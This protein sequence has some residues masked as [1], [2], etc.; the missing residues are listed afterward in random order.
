MRK[1]L[2]WRFGII[3]TVLLL[4]FWY[5]YPTFKWSSLDK[6]EQ[7]ALMD[8]YRLYDAEHPDP[9]LGER[10]ETYFTRWY[11]GDKT[12]A[13]NLG[14]DLQGGMHLVLQVDSDAAITNE[15]VRQKDNLRKYFIDEGIVTGSMS[16]EN[17]RIVIPLA[18]SSRSEVENAVAKFSQNTFIAT[19][20]GNNLL[21]SLSPD[22]IKNIKSMSVKQAL[23]TIRNRIDEF[24]VAEP[25]IQRQGENRILVQLPGV[26]D[27]DRVKDL[28]GKTA[29]LSFHIVLDGPAPKAQLLAQ[30]NQNIPSNAYLAPSRNERDRG[31]G[32]YYLLQK[33]ALV[34]G[35]DLVDARIGQDELN[36]PAVNFQLSRSG[37]V[38]F[39]KLTEANIGKQLAIVLDDAV[40]SA[41]TIRSRITSHGQITGRFTFQEVE[42]LA[43][44]LRSG[45]LP[46][47]VDIIE[48]RTVGPT[49]G[50]ES[51][52]DGLK[53]GILS[54]VIVA[55]FMIV[56]YRTAGAIADFALFL[57]IFMLLAFLSYFRATLTLPG[58]G[59]I[60]LTIGMAVDANVLVFERIREEIKKGKTLR[61]A[62]DTGYSK[63]FL[64]ILDANVTTLITAIVLFQFGTGPVK[65]FAVTLSAGI[66]ISMFTALF[67][68][69]A[70]FELL[71][72]RQWLK[73]INMGQF[74]GETH[75]PFLSRRHI[76]AVMSVIVIIVGMGT[77]LARGSKNFG[78]DFT[79]GTIL[80]VRFDQP[81]TTEEVRKALSKGGLD[82]VV[83]QRFGEQNGDARDILIRTTLKSADD[84]QTEKKG[85]AALVGEKIE[86]ALKDNLHKSFEV[87][88]TEEVGAAMSKDLTNKALLSIL[89]STIGI[90]IYISLR[91]EFRFG[92]GAVVAVFHDVLITMGA[93][94]LT[95][96]EIQLP[97]VAALLTIFGY[98]INDTI[99]VFDRIRENMRMRRGQD[100]RK[101]M[102]SSINETLSRTIITALT[103]LFAVLV[104]YFVGNEVTRDFAFALF[105]GIIVGTYSSV[106]IATP[107]VYVWQQIFGRG[108]LRAPQ[109]KSQ[110]K[111]KALRV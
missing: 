74:F 79:Q 26:E 64:T 89:Y 100:F 99:V 86:T 22:R 61:S 109:P 30:Y 111:K 2:G 11:Q 52:Q 84:G 18:G 33:D 87:E 75:L 101:L 19:P 106:F 65:G 42:D 5:I 36:S 104:L 6:Q 23:E 53:A 7:T 72:Q 37:A 56:Y 78:I 39:G 88:R 63:A 68:T 93:F 66:L 83:V 44:A 15:M 90:L 48:Q 28:L 97:V 92:L 4:S 13:L 105:I 77:F 17:Q 8:Q 35:A 9:P 60:I 34:T 102:D 50:I 25:V 16:V 49:L 70:I 69:R 62:I 51:I 96:R 103:T 41:P 10:I 14:L 54:L 85:T 47:P 80:Q 108:R 21:V 82:E 55:I 46:A 40:E 76:A 67:V 20:V 45:A 3:A 57:N 95:G 38:A 43:I 1:K 32:L 107:V 81:T 24:G 58:I 110:K 94:A 91:F 27:P 98:S 71:T 59:G 12:K 73:R 31:Q 29:Q